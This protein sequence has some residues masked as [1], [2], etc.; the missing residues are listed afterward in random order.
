[1]KAADDSVSGPLGYYAER[2]RP[3]KAFQIVSR[4]RHPYGKGRIRVTDIFSYVA[5]CKAEDR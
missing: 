3:G 4:L 1:M 5:E 2:L